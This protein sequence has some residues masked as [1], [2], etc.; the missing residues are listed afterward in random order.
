MSEP[1]LSQIK[2]VGPARLKAF[3]AAGIDTVRDL[4]AILPREYRDLTD[5]RPL[6]TL[7]AGDEA[8]VRVRVAGGVNIHRAGKL[9]I[10]KV[11][12]ADDS[13]TMSAVWYNQPWLR[14]T[15][16]PGREFLL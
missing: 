12:V 6:E 8:A 3:H 10:T 4:L 1:A 15:L 14:D 16:V 2:G 11:R 7:S 5:I 13:D 9:V